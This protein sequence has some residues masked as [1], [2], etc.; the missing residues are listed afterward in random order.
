MIETN[1]NSGGN[2]TAIS[3][4]FALVLCGF[5]W[6]KSTPTIETI[7]VTPT[8]GATVEP[9]RHCQTKGAETD[10]SNLQQPRHISTLPPGV[11]IM[12][13]VPQMAA[14]LPQRPSR[15]PWAHTGY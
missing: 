8:I 11:G 15:Q 5:P 13:G 6:T 12:D 1:P 14:D 3:R 4:A 7:V 10:M 2:S 9:L